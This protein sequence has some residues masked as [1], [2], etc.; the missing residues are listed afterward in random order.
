MHLNQPRENAS[1][2]PHLSR[3]ILS[4]R[5]V[6]NL[7]AAATLSTPSPALSLIDRPTPRCKRLRAWEWCWTRQLWAAC[8]AASTAPDASSNPPT[9]LH[10]SGSACARFRVW[11]RRE[12][13]SPLG[14]SLPVTPGGE[15]SSRGAPPGGPTPWSWFGHDSRKDSEAGR[16]RL[17]C[18][19]QLAHYAEISGSAG[20][21]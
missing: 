16:G 5:P 8:S 7:I 15:T 6:V 20:R 9:A 21:A 2:P 14:R 1:L 12:K 18:T 11:S 10:C 13:R 17:T 4:C 3:W 19:R